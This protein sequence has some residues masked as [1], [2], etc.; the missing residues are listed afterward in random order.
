MNYE[1]PQ[2]VDHGTLRDLTAAS[3]TIG[4]E[5]GIGKT[6][7]GGVGGVVGVSVGIFP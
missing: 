6:V 5:D 2:I 7:Q 3:G 4:S 1:K